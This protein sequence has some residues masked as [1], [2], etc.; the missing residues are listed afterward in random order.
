MSVELNDREKT[1]LRIIGDAC[2]KKGQDNV[3][4]DEVSDRLRI[5]GI[6]VNDVMD[7][8]YRL[9]DLGLVKL[10]IIGYSTIIYITDKGREIY[11]SL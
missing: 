2:D 1:V 11:K 3:K 6:N 9:E 7:I 4:F 5:A 10:E 8:L